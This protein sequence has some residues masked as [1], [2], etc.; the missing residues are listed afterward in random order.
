MFAKI[1][2]VSLI[3]MFCLQHPK[4]IYNFIVYRKPENA[5]IQKN[6]REHVDGIL[7]LEFQNINRKE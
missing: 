6:L 7:S 3:K 1:L 2:V 4:K 5:G